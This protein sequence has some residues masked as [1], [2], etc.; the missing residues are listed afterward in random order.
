MKQK[1]KKLIKISALA[2]FAIAMALNVMSNIP[3]GL[4]VQQVAAKETL[5]DNTGTDTGTD[6]DT[7]TEDPDKPD[8]IITDSNE[9]T[10]DDDACPK[11]KVTRTWTRSCSGGGS[12][13]C[14]A[15]PGSITYNEVNTHCPKDE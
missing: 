7:G 13:S 10:T 6:T 1:M 2:V 15:G 12:E 3:A 8:K 5:P 14:T 11:M 4:G 9:Q